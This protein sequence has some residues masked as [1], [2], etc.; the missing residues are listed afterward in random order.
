MY[1][2]DDLSDLESDFTYELE[3]PSSESL[4]ITNAELAPLP[5]GFANVQWVRFPS[6]PSE[7]THC[8][9]TVLRG[10]RGTGRTSMA[11]LGPKGC[12][13]QGSNPTVWWWSHSFWVGVEMPQE[14]HYKFPDSC[15]PPPSVVTTHYLRFN[16]VQLSRL[17]WATFQPE[18]LGSFRWGLGESL[19]ALIEFVRHPV[20]DGKRGEAPAPINS[21][22]TAISWVVYFCRWRIS[23]ILCSYC[24]QFTDWILGLD[25][26]WGL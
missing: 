26:I 4:Q 7:G 9:K 19:V 6:K 14:S 5:I 18:F 15:R 22:C 23:V 24:F 16:A 25:P 17:P 20:L 3:W 2:M 12:W 13:E 1:P 10:H 8:W 21:T 11:A